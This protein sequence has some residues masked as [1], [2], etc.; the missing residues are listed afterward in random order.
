[1]T[2]PQLP[3]PAG[4]YPDPSAP[5]TVRYWDGTAWTTHQQPAAPAAAAAPRRS[6]GA[7]T[8]TVW[9]WLIVL[10]P[11]VPALLLLFVPWGEVFDYRGILTDPSRGV[12]ASLR[13][14]TEPLY[15]AATLVGFVIYGL[16]AWFAYLD[17]RT[18]VARGIDQPFPWPWQFLSIVYVIGRTVV[19][20]RRTGRGAAPL[21]GLGATMAV[22]FIVTGVIMWLAMD[23]MLTMIQSGISTGRG[24]GS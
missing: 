9:I 23:S 18:L 17:H 22:S 12:E 4:W 1:M 6:P 2:A 15:W 10:L 20:R 11:V 14:Y 8:N 5:G 21:W 16:N 13:I 7:D 3:T 19:V 24:Y